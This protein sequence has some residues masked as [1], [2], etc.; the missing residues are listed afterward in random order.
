MN[1]AW[2]FRAARPLR[3]PETEATLS[4]EFA[5]VTEAEKCLFG[6]LRRNQQPLLPLL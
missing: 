5:A 6:V 1:P 2:C 3:Q 4:A